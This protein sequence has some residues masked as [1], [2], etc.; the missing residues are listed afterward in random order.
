MID[1][2]GSSESVDGRDTKVETRPSF[3][4]YIYLFSDPSTSRITSVI[5]R[6]RGSKLKRIQKDSEGFLDSTTNKYRY[7]VRKPNY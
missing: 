2:Q 5:I 4:S 1:L 7:N 6:E 3:A